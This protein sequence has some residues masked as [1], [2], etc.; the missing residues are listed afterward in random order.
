MKQGS[1]PRPHRS[2]HEHP[3]LH[4][5]RVC[6]LLRIRVC[7]LLRLSV[8]RRLW[9]HGVRGRVPVLV[10]RHGLG[11]TRGSRGDRRDAGDRE[12]LLDGALPDVVSAVGLDDQDYEQRNLV[13]PHCRI[14]GTSASRSTCIDTVSAKGYSRTSQPRKP[15]AAAADVSLQTVRAKAGFQSL[16]VTQKLAALSAAAPPLA[17]NKTPRKPVTIDGWTVRRDRSTGVVA[18]GQTHQ[19]RQDQRQSSR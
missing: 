8:A 14:A 6:L 11:L 9:R 3:P 1:K 16:Q 7:S 19:S 12:R 17:R 13:R 5:V 18:T 4:L 10:G 15:K 2:S